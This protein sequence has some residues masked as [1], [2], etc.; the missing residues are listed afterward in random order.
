MASSSDLKGR[1]FLRCA[2]AFSAALRASACMRSMIAWRGV[3]RST[4]NVSGSSDPSGGT[5]AISPERLGVGL[6][7]STIWWLVSPS[8]TVTLWATVLPS[9]STSITWRMLAF[10]LTA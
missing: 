1:S 2:Q 10:C 7:R 3:P 4:M 6:Q 5:A 9:E 8:G